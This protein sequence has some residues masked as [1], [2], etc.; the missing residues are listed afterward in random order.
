MESLKDI[1]KSI[2][3]MLERQTELKRSI[4]ELEI[5]NKNLRSLN[6]RMKEE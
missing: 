5:E 3:D 4:L 1:N 6:E 2:S